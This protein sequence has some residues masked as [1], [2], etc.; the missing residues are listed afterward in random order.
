MNS[1]RSARFIEFRDLVAIGKLPI[2]VGWSVP[3]TDIDLEK[4]FVIF[5]SHRAFIL[6]ASIDL[7]PSPDTPNNDKLKLIVEAVGKILPEFSPAALNC[8][9]WLDCAC[10]ENAARPPPY[11]SIFSVCD[12]VLSPMF[13]PEVEGSFTEETQYEAKPWSLGPQAYLNRAW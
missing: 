1:S 12:I 11:E 6:D 10:V 8:Y 2:G 9:L 7:R 5:V 13:D 4:S 3:L